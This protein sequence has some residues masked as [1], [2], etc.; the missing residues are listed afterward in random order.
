MLGL[1][2]VW[3]GAAVP[4]VI[5]SELPAGLVEAKTLELGLKL[6]HFAS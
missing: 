5:L 6:H 4:P 2:R 1:K 3:E